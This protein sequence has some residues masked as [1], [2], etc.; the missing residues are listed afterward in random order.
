MGVE[1]GTS[2]IRTSRRAL[3]PMTLLAGPVMARDMDA[4][5]IFRLGQVGFSNGVQVGSLRGL[6]GEPAPIIPIGFTPTWASSSG[7]IVG[8]QAYGPDGLEARAISLVTGE[9]VRQDLHGIDVLSASFSEDFATVAVVS[10][11]GHNESS[12]LLL[13]ER[14]KARPYFEYSL[15]PRRWTLA[16][17]WSMDGTKLAFAWGEETVLVDGRK[18]ARVAIRNGSLSPDGARL[19]G[20]PESRVIS[21]TDLP[22]RKEVW[23]SWTGIDIEPARWAPGGHHVLYSRVNR[24][25][26]FVSYL[27]IAE[28]TGGK[29]IW[30]RVVFGPSYSNY[31]L[32][33]K[34]W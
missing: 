27:V 26:R 34:S 21:V 28:A 23:R 4:D 14:G 29:E 17:S 12:K 3:F 5:A 11:G 24:L 15:G 10:G 1:C 13:I 32:L 25:L 18:A 6:G 7:R 30:S 16:P 2:V 19:L 22:S 8:G 9:E 33:P 20:Q 31:F